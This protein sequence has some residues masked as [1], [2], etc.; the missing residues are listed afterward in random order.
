MSVV[1]DR[2]RLAFLETA[3]RQYE[4]E[5]DRA[6]GWLMARGITRDLA[7][8]YRLGVVA[9][10]CSGHEQYQ[11][12]LAIPYLTFAGVVTIRFRALDDST[13][14][15]LSLPR[16]IGRIYNTQAFF[17]RQAKQIVITEGEFDAMVV[18]EYAGVPAV[19]LQGASAWRPLYSKCFVGYQDIL[20]VGDGDEAGIKFTDRIVNELD[21]AR[22][23][24]L[25]DG[26][27][28]NSI[29]INEG[30]QGLRDVLRL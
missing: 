24:Y 9:E 29:L 21:N 22:P 26:D 14:K 12:R 19:G 20:V 17:L 11:G 3:T 2:S 25:P 18:H 27:D 10:P 1:P 15:Y 30:P 5:I 28:C 23:I 4:T 7:R 6:A 8:E 13:P 16:D